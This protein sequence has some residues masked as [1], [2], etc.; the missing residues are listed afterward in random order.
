MPLLGGLD[1]AGGSVDHTKLLIEIAGCEFGA[2]RREGSVRKRADGRI[3]GSEFGSGSHVVGNQ[4]VFQTQHERRPVRLCM[5]LHMFTSVRQYATPKEIGA[6]PKHPTRVLR[7]A[8]PS[9]HVVFRA[10]FSNFAPKKPFHRSD[11]RTRTFGGPSPIVLCGTHRTG[12]ERGHRGRRPYQIRYLIT[13]GR[14]PEGTQLPTVLA[15]DDK[16][17]YVA[18]QYADTVSVIDTTTFGEIHRIELASSPIPAHTGL[19]PHGQEFWTL[20][21]AMSQERY[22]KAHPAPICGQSASASRRTRPSTC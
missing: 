11:L 3:D 15:P 16:F 7:T 2:I 17:L 20:N 22:S 21:H 18:N 19:T 12:G 9:L 4:L 10:S 13:S 8:P 1:R 6:H 14:L 5:S